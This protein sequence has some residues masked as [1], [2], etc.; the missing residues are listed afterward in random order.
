MS[1]VREFVIEVADVACETFVELDIVVF[2][3]RG[4]DS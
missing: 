4:V 1:V 2:T 3:L